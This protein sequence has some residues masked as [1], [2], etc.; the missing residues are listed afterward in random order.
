MHCD[1]VGKTWKTFDPFLN[2]KLLIW[3]K[4]IH[5][6]YFPSVDMDSFSMS[7]KR[8]RFQ[9]KFNKLMENLS[10]IKIKSPQLF[11]PKFHVGSN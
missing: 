1:E 5:T 2:L 11:S 4:K 7:K 10:S 3:S 8:F 9:L 6:F